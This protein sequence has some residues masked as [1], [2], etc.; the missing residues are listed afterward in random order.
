MVAV[1]NF[2]CGCTVAPAAE[3]GEAAVAQHASAAAQTSNTHCRDRS[4]CPGCTQYSLYRRS[5]YFNR[6]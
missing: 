1:I 6:R 2:R 4:P 5:P 3:N